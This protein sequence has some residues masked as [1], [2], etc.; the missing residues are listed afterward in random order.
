MAV[1]F[2]NSSSYKFI[3]DTITSMIAFPTSLLVFQSLYSLLK[4]LNFGAGKDFTKT[5]FFPFLIRFFRFYFLQ[6]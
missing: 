3:R 4:G 1:Q 2:R 5:H 6:S